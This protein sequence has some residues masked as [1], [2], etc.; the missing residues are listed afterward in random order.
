MSDLVGNT[1][2][3]FSQ[4]EARFVSLSDTF[5]FI[6]GDELSGQR[7]AKESRILDQSDGRLFSA[8]YL[9]SS[10]SSWPSA[11]PSNHPERQVKLNV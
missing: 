11:S 10:S 3:R 9:P 8:T 7:T 6:I 1:E 4:N 2:D 5:Y